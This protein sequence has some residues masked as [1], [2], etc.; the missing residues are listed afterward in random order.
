MFLMRL[1]YLKGHKT[2]KENQ[3]K[4]PFEVP[5]LKENKDNSNIFKSDQY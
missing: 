4:K 3:F 1:I 2:I 5:V